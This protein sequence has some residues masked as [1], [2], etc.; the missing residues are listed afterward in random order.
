[1]AIVL[2]SSLDNGLVAPPVV[3]PAPQRPESMT[4]LS[5]GQYLIRRLTDYG[6]RHVF[7]LPGDYVLS[8]Y[9]MLEHSP[10]QL[11]NCT[12]EDC[13]GFAADAY[14]RVHGMG[15]VC[16]T[17]GVGGLSV[18]NSIAGAYAEKSPVIMISGAPGLAERGG[19]PLLH[20][21]VREWRTQLEVFDKLCAASLEIV[22]PATAFRDI[23]FLLD[24]AHR[25]K[26]P[27]YLE[28][29]RDMVAVVP[30]QIRPYVQPPR[31]SDPAALAEAVKEAAARVA[32]AQRPVIIAGIELHRYGL[33]ADAVALAER[34]GIP[35]AATMLAK[36]VV[37]EVHPLYIGLY[38]GALGRREVTEFVEESDCLIL[39]GALLTDID[40]G[41][42]TAKLDAATSIYAA[43]DDLRISHHH[44]HDVLLDD[45][46]R[47]LAAAVP[48]ATSRPLPP[49]P[50]AALEPFVLAPAAVIT[51]TRLVRRL[52]ES[53][54]DRTIVIA[55][56][57][58]ALFASS[59][60][61]IRGQTEYIA[62]AYYTSMGFAV[63]AALGAK[64]A[65]PDLKV[66][67]LVGDGAFQMTGME[68]STI[69]RRGLAVTVIVLDNQGYGTERLLLEGSFNDINPWQYQ[70]LP[71]VLGGGTGWDV[72]T[73]GEFDE[74]L[75]A[76]LADEQAM[77]IIRV[78]IGL[79]DR[80][81]TLD[82]IAA[83][84]ASRMRR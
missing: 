81:Q 44:Y 46:I 56:V 66:I 4:S 6:L 15:A 1:M 21:R 8:F 55:D 67:A 28:L 60:L 64:T 71:E 84:L 72:R 41:I 49:G 77:T 73:E 80:S 74:A 51:T 30:D 69:V 29:P 59:D 9:S 11:V 70:R 76:A 10:L 42:F 39:L 25:L 16:V 79:D 37:S 78:H 43:S 31:A 50:A 2:G 38:E 23:D 19:N 5:I 20:H 26:R 68:L 82:R 34:A 35:I 13:A 58:D 62:P 83:G 52:D 22:D 61:V 27:V 36:S 17:Y 48:Q 32:A 47:G 24:T 7:G 3:R 14:A 57:G 75:T 40:L 53:L 54:D 18:A 63:P 33:Q 12:R 65:R 45:F